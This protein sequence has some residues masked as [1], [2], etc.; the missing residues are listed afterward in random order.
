MR[1][2]VLKRLEESRDDSTN[3]IRILELRV[4]RYT[5]LHVGTRGYM[6]LHVV[7]RG[8]TWLGSRLG[9]L[10]SLGVD[11]SRWESLVRDTL[12]RVE[13]SEVIGSRWESMGVVEVYS[14]TTCN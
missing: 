2:R 7:T 1:E 3:P 4:C 5:W 10:E 11:G 14:P 12:D 8:Y 6:W 13:Y 9:E